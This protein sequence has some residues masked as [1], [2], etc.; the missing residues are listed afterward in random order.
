MLKNLLG[1]PLLGIIVLVEP[2]HA[3][4]QQAPQPPSSQLPQ[5]YSPGPWHGPWHGPELWWIC[6]LM[7]LVMFLILGALF[8]IWPA[9]SFG[10]AVAYDG[11][12]LG[13]A[14]P[15]CA[16]YIERAVYEGRNPEGRV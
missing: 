8:L 6:P 12:G 14:N 16:A 4:V 1:L 2:L 3:I 7:M 15:F 13:P 5:G 11:S 9:T 10:T